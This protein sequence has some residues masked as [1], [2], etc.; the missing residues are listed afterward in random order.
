[1]SL[2]PASLADAGAI[3][4]LHRLTM[5]VSQPYLPELHTPQEDLR[6]FSERLLPECDTRVA[7]AGGMIAGYVAFKPGWVMHLYVHPD[8]QGVGIG[9]ML[10]AKALEDGTPRQ[11]WTFQQNTRARRF[12]ETRDFK[13]VRLTDGADNEEKT[14]DALYAWEG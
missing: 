14:P 13:L 4:R 1:M 12:Y 9:P 11:L 5:Q 10:L 2:R 7:E 8:H 6:F 3:A